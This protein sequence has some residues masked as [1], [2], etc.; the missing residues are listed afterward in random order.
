MGLMRQ[1]MQREEEAIKKILTEEQKIIYEQIKK[2][3]RNKLGEA[4]REQRKIIEER[5]F[6]RF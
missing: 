5:D 6:P 4:K 1:F 3:R 2:N